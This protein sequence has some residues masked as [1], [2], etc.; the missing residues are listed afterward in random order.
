MNKKQANNMTPRNESIK[1]VF[2]KMMEDKRAV[3]SHIQK[4]G[5]LNGFINESIVFAKPL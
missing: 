1:G 4:H 2:Q 5:T 3:Q